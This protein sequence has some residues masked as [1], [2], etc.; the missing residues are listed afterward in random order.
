MIG[1][2]L[3]GISTYI[4]NHTAFKYFL[5]PLALFWTFSYIALMHYQIQGWFTVINADNIIHNGAYCIFYYIVLLF[6]RIILYYITVCLSFNEENC[7]YISYY[8]KNFLVEATLW[9]Q[10]VVWWFGLGVLSS[11]GLGTGMHSG[12]LV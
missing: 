10:C 11:I 3:K 9:L 5:F 4:T 1:N 8:W 7:T 12:L 6:T 2:F